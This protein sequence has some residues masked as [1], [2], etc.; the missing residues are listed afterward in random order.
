M[1]EKYREIQQQPRKEQAT[2]APWSGRQIKCIQKANQQALV[3]RDWTLSQ[4]ESPQL[5]RPQ[6]QLEV[7]V[8]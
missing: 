3:R 8:K 5:P 1:V 6:I 4:S 7:L 2:M